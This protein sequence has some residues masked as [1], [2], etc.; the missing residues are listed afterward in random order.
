[1]Y[2]GEASHTVDPGLRDLAQRRVATLEQTVAQASQAAK[3][4]PKN[5]W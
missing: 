1:M 2:R 3:P 5:D 4:K